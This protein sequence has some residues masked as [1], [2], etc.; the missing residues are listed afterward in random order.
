[1]QPHGRAIWPEEL[2]L[3]LAPTPGP[4]APG[5]AGKLCL[6]S[7]PDM[8]RYHFDLDGST[9]RGGPLAGRLPNGAKEVQRAALLEFHVHLK[10]V[11]KLVTEKHCFSGIWNPQV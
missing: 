2:Y 4:W 5:K 8:E 11:K 1:M 9:Q 6:G 7:W 3:T 10:L